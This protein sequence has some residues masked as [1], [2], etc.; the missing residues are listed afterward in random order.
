MKKLFTLVLSAG[1]LFSAC[2]KSSDVS[3]DAIADSRPVAHFKINNLLSPGMAGEKVI[4]DITND[5]KNATTYFWE[6]GNQC[7]STSKVPEYSFLKCGGPFTIKLTVTGK[8]GES[9][10]YSESF[11]VKCA[12]E[13]G[14]TP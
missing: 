1:F 8:T 13:A 12:G 5:S 14:G 4:L 7:N 3:S 9:H 11:T 6:F 10:S 2:S